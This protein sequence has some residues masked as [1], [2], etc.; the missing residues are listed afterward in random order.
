MKIYAPVKNANGVWA[1]VRFV[2]G[3]GETDNQTLIAWFIKHGYEVVDES[4]ILPVAEVDIPTN[5]VIDQMDTIDLP[6]DLEKDTPLEDMTPN[7]LR[8]WAKENGYGAV[9]KNT[10]NKEKLLELIR[11]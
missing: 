4:K 8:D 11:G 9:I 5:A 7:E 6:I 2:N 3:V 10:R 1:S